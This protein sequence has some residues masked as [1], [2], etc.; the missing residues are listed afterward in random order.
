MKHWKVYCSPLWL[1]SKKNLWILDALAFWLWWQP[2]NRFCFETLCFFQYCFSFFF[3][4]QKKVCVCVCVCVG[5]GGGARRAWSSNP[6]VAPALYTQIS[7]WCT[8]P[9]TEHSFLSCYQKRNLPNFDKDV[10]SFCTYK[11]HVHQKLLFLA[12]QSKS[13]DP[14]GSQY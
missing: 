5:G 6:P 14:T 9:S 1:G 13:F 3:L 8:T 12:E 11:I 7:V 4:L 2:F 10:T